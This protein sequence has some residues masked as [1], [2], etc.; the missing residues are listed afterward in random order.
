[1]V[2]KAKHGYT[3]DIKNIS[4]TSERQKNDGKNINLG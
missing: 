3:G 1:M 2:H 4:D